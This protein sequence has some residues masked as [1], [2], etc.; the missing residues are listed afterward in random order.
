MPVELP[1]SQ[2]KIARELI[3]KALQTECGRFIEETEFLIANLKRN[4]NDSHK[5]YLELYEKMQLFDKHIA[6]R[7][8]GLTGSRYVMT[9]LKLMYDKILTEEDINRFDDDVRDYLQKTSRLWG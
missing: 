9:L 2:K 1:K 7:Y 5:I 8:D 3:Q 6:L 4:G